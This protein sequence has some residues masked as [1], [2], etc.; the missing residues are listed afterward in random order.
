LSTVYKSTVLLHKNIIYDI[1]DILRSL[2]L[3]CVRL[4]DYICMFLVINSEF[5]E[6]G[7]KCVHKSAKS[8]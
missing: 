1:S 5:S 8:D 4:T 3:F 6:S 7:F 2:K